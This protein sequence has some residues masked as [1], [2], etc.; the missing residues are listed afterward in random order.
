MV[1][2][3]GGGGRF[4]VT[5]SFVVPPEPVQDNVYVI[6]ETPKG[7][8]YVLILP[9]DVLTDVPLSVQL[10]AFVTAAQDILY[11]A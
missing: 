11:G 5:V 10:V 2:F 4:K 9:P 3:V 8:V 6:L 1:R 7:Y